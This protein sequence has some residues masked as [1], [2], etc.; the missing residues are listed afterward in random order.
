M[1]RRLLLG[2]VG[3][4]TLLGAAGCVDMT[5]GEEE[6]PEK[7]SETSEGTS[8]DEE[9]GSEVGRNGYIRPEGN[10]DTIPTELQCKQDDFTRHPTQYEEVE[11]G[12]TADLSLR[13]NKTSFQFGETAR[14]SLKNTSS[15]FVSIGAKE[16][17]QIEVYTEQGWQEL[18]GKIS[19]TSFDYT[20]LGNDLPPDEGLEW[21]IKLTEDGIAEKDLIVCP[22]LVAGRYR[23][24]YWGTDPALAVAFDIRR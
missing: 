18:R 12:D 1:N 2:N 15:G 4:V 23:F 7:S 6:P 14:I 20:D 17:Y 22:E 9:S 16:H 8:N 19:E 5:N 21:T 13:V 11:W 3:S 24:V 10:P